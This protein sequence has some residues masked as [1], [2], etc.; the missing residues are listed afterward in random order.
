MKLFP[1]F[2]KKAAT[3]ETERI[4]R[5]L[6][7]RDGT[8]DGAPVSH[9]TA[10]AVPVVFA[11]VRVISEDV[12]KLSCKLKIVDGDVGAVAVG[13]PENRILS[14]VAKPLN[15]EDDGFT[16]M[17]MIEYVLQSA[18][19][20]GYGVA[21]QNIFGGITREMEPIR[22]G[23]WRRVEVIGGL[24]KWEIYTS[25]KAWVEVPRQNLFIL[26]GPGLGADVSLTVRNA[27]SLAMALDRTLNSLALKGGRPQGILAMEPLKGG[28]EKAESFMKRLQETFG[29]SS[30]GGMMPADVG[31]MDLIKLSLTPEE[32]QVVETKSSIINDVARAF[33]VQPARLMHEMSGQTHASAYQWNVAHVNDTIQ[34][35]TK[36]F[37]QAFHKDVLRDRASEYYVDFDMK[38]L[39]AGS[40]A[41][42]AQFHTAMRQ[43]GAI[44]PYEVARIEDLPTVGI[45]TDPA[46]PLLTN[47]NPEYEAD[48]VRDKKANA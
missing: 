38:S 21:Y 30:Q 42:R 37:K 47:P 16:A 14:S 36:R 18:A 43:L 6:A 28:T 48:N 44:S 23:S 19:L 46:F 29:P 35:W 10:L 4:L 26:R 34:P 40:P 9:D 41:E 31:T 33:R 12:A 17:E 20:T 5:T 27:I 8:L 1:W 11:A 7:G 22:R 39:M 13:E 25:G 2:Q 24:D 45:S 15:E 3:S 32:L